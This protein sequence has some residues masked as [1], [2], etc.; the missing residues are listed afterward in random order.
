MAKFWERAEIMQGRIE[1]IHPLDEFSRKLAFGSSWDIAKRAGH[2]G[3]IEA[4][5]L[6]FSFEG[7]SPDMEEGITKLIETWSENAL[8]HSAASD[9]AGVIHIMPSDSLNAYYRGEAT[10]LSGI[11]MIV[12]VMGPSIESFKELEETFRFLYGD[13]VYDGFALWMEEAVI[14]LSYTRIFNC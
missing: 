6:Y 14:G 12:D 10:E 3:Y 7:M 8:F 9:D 11:A 13:G 4:G 2:E 1:K 5:T